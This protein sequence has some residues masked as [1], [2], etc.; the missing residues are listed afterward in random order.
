MSLF[1]DFTSALIHQALA[2]NL[3]DD[4]FCPFAVCNLAVVVVE[5]KLANV[6]DQMLLANMEVGAD[7]P[8]L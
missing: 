1:L 8:A 3:F 2:I 5:I 4:N 6:A 7:N